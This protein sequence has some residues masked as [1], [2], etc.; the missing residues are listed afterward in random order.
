MTD[1]SDFFSNFFKFSVL[2][3]LM[4]SDRGRGDCSS[5]SVDFICV[6]NLKSKIKKSLS[7]IYAF[8]CTVHMQSAYTRSCIGNTPDLRVVRVA[9]VPFVRG[10][11]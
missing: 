9:Y 6:A 1:K 11:Q 2:V 5:A 7:A 8:D 3:L 10:S 4:Y